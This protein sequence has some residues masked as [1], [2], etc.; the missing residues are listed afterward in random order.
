MEQAEGL[1]NQD[2]ANVIIFHLF[3]ALVITSRLDSGILYPVKFKPLEKAPAVWGKAL[4]LYILTYLT[5]SM[6]VPLEAQDM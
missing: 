4:N 6:P 3:S 5:S 2:P 1:G